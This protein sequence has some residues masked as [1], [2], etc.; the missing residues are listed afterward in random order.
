MRII[1]AIL[2]L[3]V[4]GYLVS[5]CFHGM[6]LPR[7]DSYIGGIIVLCIW[8]FLITPFLSSGDVWWSEALQRCSLGSVEFSAVRV[9]F[10][11]AELR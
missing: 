4:T 3:L 10:G 5:L 11:K 9:A 8:F 2:W 6:N 7:D 1:G